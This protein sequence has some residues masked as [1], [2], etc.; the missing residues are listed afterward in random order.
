MG[1]RQWWDFGNA[2]LG[3]MGCHM[4]DLPFSALDLEYPHTVEAHSAEPA[5]RESGPPWLISKW[6][7]PARGDLPPVELT[8][9][10]GNANKRP[11]LQ[12]QYNMP[13]WPEGTILVGTKG[14][15]IADYGRFKLY[16]EEKFRGVG[17]PQVGQDRSHADNWLRACKSGDPTLAGCQFEYSGP[18]TETVL[19]GI[20]AFRAGEKL[21]WDAKNMKVTNCAKANRFT[22]RE[23]YRKGWEI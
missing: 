17:R 2:R 8:W 5:H 10:D 14:I 9:Y 15:L 11:S 1:W 21:V 22:H 23:Q 16:P 13:D 7:F 6:T 19:L 18:L 3:D 20:V 12:K 4:I